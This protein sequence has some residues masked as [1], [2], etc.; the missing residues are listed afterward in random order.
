MEREL[1][2]GSSPVRGRVSIGT[3]PAP[4]IGAGA[5]KRVLAPLVFRGASLRELRD[6]Q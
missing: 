1:R 3:S 6:F 2:E 4:G 5:A